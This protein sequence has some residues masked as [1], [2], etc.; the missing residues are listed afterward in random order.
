M[1]NCDDWVF[2]PAFAI[3]RYPETVH[4]KHCIEKYMIRTSIISIE[5]CKYFEIEF[6]R[7]Q[8]IKMKPHAYLR[9][10]SDECTRSRVSP[11]CVWRSTK[12]S[13]L[14]ESP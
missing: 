7:R 9:E 10:E 1:K 14:K 5:D 4:I 12:F 8:S 11:G 2:L 13:S 6:N 3:D